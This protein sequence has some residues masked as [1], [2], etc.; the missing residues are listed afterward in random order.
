MI[1]TC[2]DMTSISL[3]ISSS[4]DRKGLK[5]EFLFDYEIQRDFHPSNLT[6]KNILK[7]EC[8]FIK[9]SKIYVIPSYLNF[10]IFSN[11]VRELEKSID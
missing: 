6:L 9:L 8:I 2:D 1:I 10:V 7:K 11:T 4:K 5:S 3:Y